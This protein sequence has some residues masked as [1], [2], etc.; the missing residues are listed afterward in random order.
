MK[1]ERRGPSAAGARRRPFAKSPDHAAAAVALPAA[2]PRLLVAALLVV[3]LLAVPYN[4]GLQDVVNVNEA[5]R[6]LPPVEMLERGDW[7]VPTIDGELY[8]AKPPL[9]YW[10]IGASY[11]ASG[12]RSPLAGRVPVALVCLLTALGVLVVG[13]RRGGAR[14]GLWSALILLSSFFFRNRAQEAEIDPVL[15]G[16]I[17]GMVYWQWRALTAERWLLPSLAGGLF[18]GGALLLK[19]PVAVPFLAASTFAIAYV[20]RPPG[21]RVAAATGLVLA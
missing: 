20:E 12:S 18:A 5:Q 8:L 7:V 13:W 2:A 9:V 14:V 1:A 17:F 19:G 3:A 15:T 6:L 11:L 16:A 21:K 10:L 4:L